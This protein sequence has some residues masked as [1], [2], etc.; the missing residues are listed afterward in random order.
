MNTINQS[1]NF[2]LRQAEIVADNANQNN[3]GWTDL[4]ITA[5]SEYAK[6]SN[7]PFTIES[8]RKN[9]GAKLPQPHDAR[10]WG[11]VTRIAID[12]RLIER[13]GYNRAASSHGCFKPTY[14]SVRAC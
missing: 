5:L 1:L 12:I 6:K 4:A 14:V 2:G 13:V 3:E 10:A 11:Q 8:A 9:I 7:G